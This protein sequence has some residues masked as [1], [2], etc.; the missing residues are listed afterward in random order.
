MG[1]RKAVVIG[2]SVFVIGAALA[3]SSI[4][5]G[6][7]DPSEDEGRWIGSVCPNGEDCPAGPVVQVSATA[8][9]GQAGDTL[10]Y[11][12]RSTDGAVLDHDSPTTT[13]R[14]PPGTGLH[15]VYVLVSNGKGGYAEERAVVNTDSIGTAFTPRPTGNEY[16]APPAPEVTTGTYQ[17]LSEVPDLSFSVKSGNPDVPYQSPTFY[18]DLRGRVAIRGIP[19][20]TW[21]LLDLVIGGSDD[22]GLFYSNNNNSVNTE[23]SVYYPDQQLLSASFDT[24]ADRGQRNGQVLLSDFSPCGTVNE[25][26]GVTSTAIIGGTVNG[27]P[28]GP[29]R[30]NLGSAAQG[31]PGGFYLPDP[32]QNPSPSD[33][34][35]LTLGVR[36]IDDDV[37]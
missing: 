14:L 21:N 27:I 12:W 36:R 4:V 15:F 8:A 33:S 37:V 2:F 5:R 25:F 10:H 19:M 26:F 3:G 34:V 1:A 11:R 17:S 16:K 22:G 13:W 24:E 31:Y 32:V 18:S 35:A 28:T 29:V 23:P 20:D 30:A 9:P 7:A 6:Q